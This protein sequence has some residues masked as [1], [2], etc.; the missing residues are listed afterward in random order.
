MQDVGIKLLTSPS[1][2]FA[3]HY[4]RVAWRQ[5]YRAVRLGVQDVAVKLLTNVDTAQLDVFIEV[6]PVLSEESKQCEHCSAMPWP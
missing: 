5:V 2:A 6:G 1:T 3:G 4:N